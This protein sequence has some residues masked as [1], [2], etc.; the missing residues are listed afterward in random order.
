[1]ISNGNWEEAVWIELL[2]EGYLD[3]CFCGKKYCERCNTLLSHFSVTVFNKASRLCW[4]VLLAYVR[5]FNDPI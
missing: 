5:I 2:A 1:M 4:S 3:Y